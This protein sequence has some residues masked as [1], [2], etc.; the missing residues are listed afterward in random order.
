MRFNLRINNILSWAH[1]RVLIIFW[2]D[3]ELTYRKVNLNLGRLMQQLSVP[4]VT[5]ASYL[6]VSVSGEEHAE[7]VCDV[8]AQ[9]VLV[10]VGNGHVG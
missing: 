10:I 2:R 7:Q 1:G 4:G 3:I 6:G 9:Q 8:T 5:I